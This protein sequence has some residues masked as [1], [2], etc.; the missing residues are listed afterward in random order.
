MANKKTENQ[1]ETARVL[2]LSGETQ[3]TIAERIGVSRITVGKWIKDFEWSKQRAAKTI[4]R[5]ELTNKLLSAI[6]R[7]IEQVND[8]DDPTLMAG[9]ADKL[10]KMSSVVEKLDKK[11]N[12][13]DVIEVFIAFSKWLEHRSQTD[14]DITPDFLKLLNKYQDKFIMEKMGGGAL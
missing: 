12:I 6:D 5:N 13:V 4:T 9:L 8:S 7:L 14:T 1:R 11:A 2:Y 10:S 3:L